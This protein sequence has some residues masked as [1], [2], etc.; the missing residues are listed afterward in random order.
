[1]THVG[2]SGRLERVGKVTVSDPSYHGGLGL[3]TI[4]YNAGLA[5]EPAFY[6]WW[7]TLAS[8]LTLAA[9]LNAAAEQTQTQLLIPRDRW[10]RCQPP[11]ELD[12]W[13]CSHNVAINPD[14]GECLTCGAYLR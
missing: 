6:F 3:C 12:E 14:T 5:C 8:N 10:G 2:S 4:L 11:F 7:A 1:M 13:T 9:L